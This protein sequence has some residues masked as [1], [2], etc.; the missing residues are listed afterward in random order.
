MARKTVID[1]D[2]GRGL[3]LL[4]GAEGTDQLVHSKGVR[5]DLPGFTWIMLSGVVALD[6]DLEVVGEGDVRAQTRFVLE[7]IQAD[8]RR[9][10]ASIDDICRVRVYVVG[11][12]PERFKAI[13]EERARFFRSQHYPA[14]TLV[15]VA[16][17]IK[18]ELLIEI[19]ADAVILGDGDPA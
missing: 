18:P 13:H 4:R 9:Q 3:D 5:L 15:E 10:G 17:L 14:S 12:T 2:Y 19:D 7:E 1:A 16:G 6:R 8:L 11:L